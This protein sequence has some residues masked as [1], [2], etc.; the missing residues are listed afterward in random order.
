MKILIVDDEAI[1]RKSLLR[2]GESMGHEVLTAENGEEGIRLWQK[3]KPSVVFLDVL[4]PGI[5]GIQVLKEVNRGDSAVI[6]ISA[7]TGEYN[8]EAA[9]ELGADL[10]IPKPFDNIFDVIKV[11]ENLI[12]E[13][14]Q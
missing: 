10:Y 11:A 13:R 8:L 3:L 5:S 2:A 9:K 4:M 1:I 12:V 6:L 14:T 7:Y